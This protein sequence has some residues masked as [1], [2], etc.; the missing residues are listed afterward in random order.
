MYDKITLLNAPSKPI[1]E[2]EEVELNNGR[3][4]YNI[5]EGETMLLCGISYDT[6]EEAEKAIEEYK[7]L[8]P[9][10]IKVVKTITD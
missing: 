2:I 9:K 6:I 3:K 10:S 5:K 4:Y 7:S 8:Q 1:Y